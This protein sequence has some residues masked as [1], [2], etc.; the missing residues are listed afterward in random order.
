M[1]FPNLIPAVVFLFSFGS[2]EAQLSGNAQLSS[3]SDHSGIKVKFIASSGTC[4]TDSCLTT[5]SG[6]YSLTIAG[7]FIM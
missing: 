2:L 7:G 5:S 1:K 3:Q 4:V 6:N